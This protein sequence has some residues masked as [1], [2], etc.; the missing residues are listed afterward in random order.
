MPETTMGMVG[1]GKEPKKIHYPSTLQLDEGDIADVKDWKVGGTYTVQ[2]TIKE[3][4]ASSGEHNQIAPYDDDDKDKVH[5]RFEVISA[6]V[7]HGE[8]EEK[9]E[10]KDHDEEKENEVENEEE[11]KDDEEEKAPEKVIGAVKRKIGYKK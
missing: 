3:V 10:P 2:L 9:A 4:Q 1:K 5:A 6:K 11:E 8:S 7:V